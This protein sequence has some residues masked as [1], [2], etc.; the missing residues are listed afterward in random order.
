M[1][2][3]MTGEPGHADNAASVHWY[4]EA[5]RALEVCAPAA[6]GTGE[7]SAHTGT[8]VRFG[9]GLGGA[10]GA[11]AIALPRPGRPLRPR[12]PRPA[13]AA[14]V[15][16]GA[17]AGAACSAGAPGGASVPPPRARPPR[18]CCRVPREPRARPELAWAFPPPPVYVTRRSPGTAWAGALLNLGPKPG[19][20]SSSSYG[21]LMLPR[22]T[23]ASAT[24]SMATGCAPSPGGFSPPRRLSLLRLLLLG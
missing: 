2:P 10:G 15:V 7:R 4:M 6:C 24:G 20:G 21:E 11:P 18:L 16:A 8:M 13:G 1:S 9:L 23:P 22:D 12:R 3:L 14:G 5:S 17:V 19:G